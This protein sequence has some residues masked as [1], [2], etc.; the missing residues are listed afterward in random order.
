MF[1]ELLYKI[2]PI[3]IPIFECM[4]VLILTIGTFKAFFNYM[5]ALIKKDSPSIRQQYAYSMVMAL[6][7]KLAAEILKTVIVR[8]LKDLF[9]LGVVFALRMIMTFV[10]EREMKDT[11]T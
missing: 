9:I 3:L 7:F 1:E 6:E 11:P 5:Y 8:E 10:L 4:G 2:I